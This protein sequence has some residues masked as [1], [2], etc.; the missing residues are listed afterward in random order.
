MNVQ[1][2]IFWVVINAHYNIVF[3]NVNQ[4]DKLKS[5]NEK[6]ENVNYPTEN[7][8]TEP[9]GMD[10]SHVTLKIIYKCLCVSVGYD[11]CQ[12]EDF[13]CLAMA[14]SDRLGLESIKLLHRQLDDDK[15]G[16]IDLSESDDVRYFILHK[17]LD[18]TIKSA[19][20]NYKLIFC[21]LILELR[22]VINPNR[23]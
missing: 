5:R 1:C 10:F 7:T 19:V 4:L 12:L 20:S 11:T 8:S 18:L 16:N 2:L 15:D 6:S 14:Q 17:P 23:D 22:S 13:A 3:G 21:L 9:E